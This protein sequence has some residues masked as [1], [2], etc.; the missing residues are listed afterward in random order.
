MPDRCVYDCTNIS[1]EG[2]W[3]YL[4]KGISGRMA[5]RTDWDYR[6]Y[7]NKWDSIKYKL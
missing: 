7:L 1:I 5:D 3:Y 4:S 2:E 6:E